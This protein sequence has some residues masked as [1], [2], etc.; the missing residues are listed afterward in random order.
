MKIGVLVAYVAVASAA[1]YEEKFRTWMKNHGITF[2]P[3]EWFHR[4]ENF[5]LNDQ[6][7]EASNQASGT[8]FTLGHNEYSHLT[9]DEFKTKLLGVRFP[10]GYLAARQASP[11]SP[12]AN[13]SNLPDSIDWVEKGA[14]TPVKNQGMCG[15]CW[16]FSTTGA[17]EG[18]AF[19]ATNKLVSLS[20]QEL[21]DC[22][23]S[24]N[25]CNGGLM[26]NA[27]KWIKKHKG[28]CQEDDYKYH[29]NQSTCALSNCSPVTRV[30][31]YVDVDPNDEQELK[32][33]V[34]EQPVA[35][36]IQADQRE[37]QFYKSGVFDKP[38]GTQLDHGVLVVGYG[39]KSGK[40]Y[41]KVK[42]SWGAGWGDAGYIYLAR[43]LGPK[44]GQCGVAMAP[45]YPFA[46][47]IS[48]Q[49]EVEKV[50][51]STPTEVAKDIPELNKETVSSSV[52][53]VQCGDITSE[54]V[55]FQNLTVTP[56][57]PKPGKAIQLVGS[58]VVKTGFATAP[59]TIAVKL[60]G[61]LVFSHNGNVCGS[62]HV[63]LPLGLGHIDLEGLKCPVVPG[64]FDGLEM[65]LKLPSIAPKSKYDILLTSDLGDSN[66]K[67]EVFCVQ[68]KLD[69]S[70]SAEE[71]KRTEVYELLATS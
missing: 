60:G 10:K 18:A 36:A 23:D 65:S 37:F 61:R 15:S 30:T 17:I 51:E 57:H 22:D 33:A 4:F 70:D 38:C 66:S 1:S 2:S 6:F 69:L 42:N 55:T 39:E 25:G 26:D 31:G 54:L 21:V 9:Y 63:P 46:A 40:K 3:V 19:V 5:I 53:I 64:K 58:G 49:D 13:R 48:A 32:A 14:V 35:V 44:Q 62:T 34:A 56:P 20:E 12:R 67:Q 52:T 50:A 68:V 11:R 24:D 27:F 41:W 71:I 47:V 43:E 29:A 16:A 45:S 28:L 59:L 8:S 7:I